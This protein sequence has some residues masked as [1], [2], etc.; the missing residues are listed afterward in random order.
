MKPIKKIV[1][2]ISNIS[3]GGAQRITLT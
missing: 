1:F 3:I 2:V